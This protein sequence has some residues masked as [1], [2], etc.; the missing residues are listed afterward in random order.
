MKLHKK[1]YPFVKLSS[2]ADLILFLISAELKSSKVFDTLAS[3]GCEDCYYKS[4]YCPVIL[5]LMGFE[6]ATDNLV[7]LYVKLVDKYSS[8]IEPDRESVAKQALKFYC[9]LRA[10]KA[11]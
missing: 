6:E 3:L 5:N 7:G 1:N 2:K 9:E 4:D 10:E 8:K 11:E